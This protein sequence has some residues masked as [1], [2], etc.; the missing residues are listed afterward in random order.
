MKLSGINVEVRRSKR[1]KTINL[2]VERDGSVVAN[3]PENSP[4][5]E[6]QQLLKTREEWLHSKLLIKEQALAKEPFPR[7]YLPG[8]GFFYLGKKYRLK[9]LKDEALLEDGLRFEKEW[10]LLPES[11][12]ENGK[13]YF[14]NWYKENGRKWL[15]NNIEDLAKLVGAKI[16]DFDVLDLGYRWGSCNQSGKIMLHW[17]STM[18]PV[19]VLKYLVIHELVHIEIHNHS[20]KFYAKL[21]KFA[22]NYE[23]MENWLKENGA[24]YNL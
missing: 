2:V 22:P 23:D 1:R 11:M 21:K 20:P 18:L 6:I 13:K 8:E 14:I 10:F 19:K 7:Q 24:R 15:A 9:L 4:D 5:S 17:R 16:N 3:V 12:A